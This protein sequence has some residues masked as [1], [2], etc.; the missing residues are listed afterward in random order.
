MILKNNKRID[1]C[2]D[3]V[4][5][6]TINPFLGST[7]PYGYLLCQGQKVSK[8]IYKELYEIC[9][10]TFGQS[11]DT[12]FYLPDLRGQ[13]IA[14]YKEGDITFGTLGGLIGSLTHL[15]S[16]GNH[17]LT[18]AES[19][20]RDHQHGGLFLDGTEVGIGNGSSSGYSQGISSGNRGTR[21]ITGQSTSA[22]ASQPH[23]HGD[24]S[25]NSSLQP[26]IVLNWI[27]KAFQLMPNQSYVSSIKQNSDINTYSCNYIN[28]NYISSTANT[29]LSGEIYL[30]GTHGISTFTA[31]NKATGLLWCDENHSQLIVGSTLLST[32][33]RSSDDNLY[34][35]NQAKNTSYKI[36]D[37]YNYNNYAVSKTDNANK[38]ILNAR[39]GH[40][41]YDGIMSYQT[42]GNEAWVFS[43]KNA[44]T[45]FMV[46]NGED[47]AANISSERWLSLTP[48][49]QVKQ[50]CVSIGKLIPNDSAPTH[51]LY[52][53]GS[54]C[55]TGGISN[56]TDDSTTK[57]YG[58]FERTNELNFG[59]SGDN[60]NN[61][62]YFSYRAKDSRPI[63]ANFIFGGNSGTAT[64]KAAAYNTGSLR[65]L[66]E[67][68]EQADINAL[69]IINNT[70]ITKFNF[71]AD[72]TKEIRIGYIADDTH[73]LLSGPNHDKM[74]LNNCV[75]VM[76]KA[77]QELSAENQELRSSLNKLMKNL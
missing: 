36:L 74:D 6:G 66:K 35:M 64:L 65:E 40:N 76:M 4:P 31:D 25:S 5:I 9:G 75:G 15:H 27:V 19:G 10:D 77:I 48:G 11:T 54:L 45:S 22:P 13:T 1:G 21:Y 44:V 17:T 59:G 51:R 70:L 46:V 29:S 3:T 8:A 71:K 24:T 7:A 49:L 41:S 58:Y 50:N 38:V 14:G 16:T 62:M 57:C 53:A 32:T 63:I 73:E 33:I 55:A 39:G 42:A 12:E 30:T 52:V 68:I 43:T 20:L 23:N 61:V 18:A 60:T 72:E 26:T 34:H 67:N 69:D 2:S 37:S 56:D 47:T 28:N